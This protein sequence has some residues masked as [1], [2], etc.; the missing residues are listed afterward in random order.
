MIPRECK[1]LAEVDFPIAEVS[2]HSAREKSIRHGHPS[3]LHLWWARRPLAAC[4]AMLMALLLPDPCDH[5]CPES[6]KE[7][8][9]AALAR[10]WRKPARKDEDLREALLNFIAAFA[11]WERSSEHLYLEISRALIKAAYP[12]ELPL[13]A[14]SFAGGGSIPLEALRI[15]C[16]AFANDLN[17]VSAL[18]CRV[19]LEDV[20]R[21]GSTLVDAF[22]K[23]I[24]RLNLHL[25]GRLAGFYPSD[26]VHEEPTA[27]LW[28]RVVQCESPKCGA[29]IPLLRSLWLSRRGP[30]R[31]ALKVAVKRESGR[32]RPTV[33]LSVYGPK[34]DAA[35]GTG[36]VSG[37][38][39]ICPA[40]GKP[41]LRAAVES[42]LKDRQGGTDTARLIAVMVATP[43]GRQFRT[44]KGCD[45][46]GIERVSKIDAALR[47]AKY[48]DALSVYPNERINPER[49]SP[50]ARGLSAVTR[51][52]MTTFSDCYLPRQRVVLSEFIKFVRQHDSSTSEL[53]AAVGRCLL[54]TVGRCVD[55]WSSSSR[56]DSSRDTVTGSFSKQAL[57][58]VWDF[59]EA[60]PFSQWSGGLANA[61]E[62]ITQV[63]EY[64]VNSASRPAQVRQGDARSLPLPA[65]SVGVWFTDPPYYDSVPYADLADFFYCWL[66]RAAAQIDF[67]RG[68]ID[69]STGLTPKAEECVWNQAHRVDGKPKDPKFFEQCVC[70][71]FDQGKRILDENGIGCVVFAHK[72][73]KAGR[74]C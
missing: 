62:W 63:M 14:D 41:V 22:N 55:R 23:E 45:F 13:V 46:E 35:V 29:E 34:E 39:A 70:T 12:E 48:S 27:Y 16:E 67:S 2:K 37:G 8:A 15:G 21:F 73:T 31:S 24:A 54:I 49:P 26:G 18:M 61:V 71:A 53:D 11:S 3:T 10:M 20:P 51:Y 6:F 7:D 4:R 40:C 47:K 64:A 30:S 32:E 33:T 28:A 60:N 69:E 44:P 25:R 38:R 59:C 52:G 36:T 65:R 66:K 1:R 58:M 74:R 57:Q 19:L 56:L 42:Q 5:T 50:N 72:S 43:K 17:P 9:R 68:P